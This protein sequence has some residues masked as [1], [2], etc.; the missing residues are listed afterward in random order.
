[1]NLKATAPSTLCGHIKLPA[2]KSISNR[3]L[4]LSQLAGGSI[5][6]NNISDCD[7]TRAMESGVRQCESRR[8]REHFVGGQHSRADIKSARAERQ[9][10]QI[11]NIDVGAAGTAM[12]FLTAFFASTPCDV[13]ITGT[14]RMLH[15]PIGVLVN[16]LRSLGADI[17]YAGEEGFPPLQIKGHLLEGGSVQLPGNVSSQYISAL[18]MIAPTM[19]KGLTLSIT[20]E[21]ISRPYI[22][23]TLSLMRQFGIA[24]DEGLL[25]VV[26]VWMQTSSRWS[27][28]R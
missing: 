4:L 1:M 23:I 13:V 12:R 19:R 18:L 27:S 14:E 22:N 20:G 7:D 10:Y 8:L 16:A 2:S 5:A 3:M 28:A 26:P 25:S 24:I 21:V 6:L 15:R 11:S 9:S 17:S